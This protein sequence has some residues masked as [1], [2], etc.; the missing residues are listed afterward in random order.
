MSDLPPMEFLLPDSFSI[1]TIAGSSRL[2]PMGERRI[3]LT[4]LDTFDRRLLNAGVWLAIEK[5]E[6]GHHRCVA[7]SK[8]GARETRSW[9]GSAHRTCSVT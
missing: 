2:V 4:L 5:D 3:H 9:T 8:E 1:E 6:D 7:Q